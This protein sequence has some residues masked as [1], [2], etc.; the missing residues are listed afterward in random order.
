MTRRRSKSWTGS[1]L[2]E[3]TE[4]QCCDRPAQRDAATLLDDARPHR[5]RRPSD[6]A[7]RRSSSTRPVRQGRARQSSSDGREFAT[8][9]VGAHGDQRAA[10]ARAIATVTRFTKRK[11]FARSRRERTPVWSANA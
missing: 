9:E 5:R 6:V 4:R 2:D 10:L 11:R 8:A 3:R 1:T 7:M